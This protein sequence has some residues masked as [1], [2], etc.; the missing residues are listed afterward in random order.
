[1]GMGSLLFLSVLVVLFLV[2]ITAAYKFFFDTPGDIE[3]MGVV[4]GIF[5]GLA[6]TCLWGILLTVNHWIAL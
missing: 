1:M 5:A 3:Y 4:S 2:F 6:T